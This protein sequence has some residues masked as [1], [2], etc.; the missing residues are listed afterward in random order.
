MTKNLV[1]G[2]QGFVGKPFTEY[3]RSI[4]EEVVECDIKLG[5]E[6]DLRRIKVD[7]NDIDRVF[8][9]AWDV[10]GA[11]YLYKE[12]TQLQQLD[13]NLKLLTN[14]MVQLHNSKTPFLFVSSQLAEECNT[15]YGVTKRLGEVWTRILKGVRVRLWNVYG[16]LEEPS[17]RTHVVSDF[18]HQAIINGEIRMMTTGEELRQFIHIDDVC[19]ALQQAISME[20]EGVYDVTTF[21]WIT[22]R[23]IAEII[24]NLTGARVIPGELVGSTPLTP[25]RGKITGWIPSV[26]IEDGLQMMVTEMNHRLEKTGRDLE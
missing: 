10:G 11:K 1:M 7:L 5:D 12:E 8:F 14:V 19:K 9:L 25:I 4:G 15:A 23:E 6:H 13:W 21:K 24:A 18:V 3:L 2:S 16:P 20:L 22:V 17:E 26:R